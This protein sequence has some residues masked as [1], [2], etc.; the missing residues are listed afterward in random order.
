MPRPTLAFQRQGSLVLLVHAEVNPSEADWKRYLDFAEA[1]RDDIT[2]FFVLSE[3]GGPNGAQRRELNARLRPDQRGNR[4]AV[5]TGNLLVRGIVIALSNFN[6]KIRAFSPKDV[7]AA[8]V[9]LE[10]P[11]AERPAVLAAVDALRRELAG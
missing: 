11:P 7:G 2:G 5:L 4:T 10:V 1:L 3:G 6:P 8:L 9:Y